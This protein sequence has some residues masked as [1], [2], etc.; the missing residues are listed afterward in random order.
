MTPPRY[1]RLQVQQTTSPY[2]YGITENREECC[3]EIIGNSYLADIDNLYCGDTVVL[4]EMEEVEGGREP[5][6]IRARRLIIEPDYLVDISTLTACFSESGAHPMRYVL[7]MLAP[8]ESTRHILLGNMANQ[9]LDDCVNHTPERPAS[10]DTS[11]RK[12]FTADALKFAICPDIN[13]A[14]FQEAR[15]Q[16]EHI[17]TSVEALHRRYPAGESGGAMLEPSFICPALGIQGRLDYLHSDLHCL[18]ELKSGK[19]DEYYSAPKVPSRAIQH[20]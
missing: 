1:L 2:I 7:S 4:L 12:A 8:K 17:R 10:Y 6:K 20:K 19:A 5:A 16:Y 3:A 15:S 11:I 18:V 13:A 9:F 14:F